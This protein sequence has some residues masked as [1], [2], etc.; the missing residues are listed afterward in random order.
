MAGQKN[1][2]GRERPGRHRDR[3]DRNHSPDLTWLSLGGLLLSRARLRFARQPNH[4]LQPEPTHRNF[5]TRQTR[6]PAPGVGITTKPLANQGETG[7]NK[8]KSPAVS[9]NYQSVHL[10]IL[11]RP[12]VAGF[13]APN[14][15]SP[16]NHSRARRR[17]IQVRCQIRLFAFPAGIGSDDV[18]FVLVAT[19]IDEMEEYR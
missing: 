16:A 13:E 3:A 12:S 10:P 14:D 9:S 5:K 7:E 8:A 2:S 17:A 11:T 19:H 15:N 18:R 4:S 6:P 1:E